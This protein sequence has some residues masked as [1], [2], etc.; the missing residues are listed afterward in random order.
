VSLALLSLV[1]PP[2][3]LAA[4]SLGEVA[5]RE[6]ARRAQQRRPPTKTYTDAELEATR[7]PSPPP[8]ADAKAKSAAQP[9]PAGRP[10]SSSEEAGGDDPGLTPGTEQEQ[11][12]RDRAEQLREARRVAEEQARSLDERI[13]TLMLDSDPNPPDL[14]DPQRLQ[15]REQERQELTR[16]LE[17]V[18]A[19]AAQAE[20]DFKDLEEEARRSRVPHTWLEPR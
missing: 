19:A 15:K 16:Q 5:A 12:W 8:A 2:S 11:G 7:A 17:G 13:K 4:Q 18:R 20:R 6:Q 10:A 3:V 9:L 1:L 14:M